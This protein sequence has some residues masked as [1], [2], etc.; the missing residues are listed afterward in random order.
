V[1]TLLRVRVRSRSCA[2]ACSRPETPALPTRF[3]DEPIFFGEA[4]HGLATAA[5]ETPLTA[6]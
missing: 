6:R 1:T 3:H 2:R 5:N 4:T